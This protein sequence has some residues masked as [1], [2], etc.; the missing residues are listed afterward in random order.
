M[1]DEIIA[2]ADALHINREYATIY[3]LLTK[4]NEDFPDNIEIMWR[5]ARSYYDKNEE[6]S[7]K[8]QKQELVKK[9]LDL[10]NRGLEMDDNH[11]AMNKWWA[12][13]TN[14]MGDYI[15]QKEKIANA[16][17]IK[18]HITK[19]LDVKRDATS[20][21]I[22]GRWCY[23]ISNI[24]WIERGIATALFGSP[25]TSTFGEALKSFLECQELDPTNIRNSL[26][27]GDT[28]TALKDY[29][30]AKEWYVKTAAMEAKSEFEKTLIAEAQKKAK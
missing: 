11:W 4:A 23:T 19:S 7:D 18:E 13:F 25:P 2:Q 16:I 10:I 9:G 28:Y 14:A 12:I 22:L 17:K 30:K 20:L 6:I 24:S 1:A 21:H 3:A 15:S 29:A 27:V 5:L 8:T 26:F